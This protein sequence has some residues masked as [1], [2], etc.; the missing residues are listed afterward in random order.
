MVQDHVTREFRTLPTQSP[1]AVS[2][3]DEAFNTALKPQKDKKQKVYKECAER[4]KSYFVPERCT[5]PVTWP[6]SSH[7]LSV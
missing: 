2:K 4:E 3:E 6:S 5:A 7:I 1:A